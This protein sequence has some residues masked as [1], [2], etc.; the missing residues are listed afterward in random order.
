MRIRFKDEE[1]KIV[2]LEAVEVGISVET[3]PANNMEEPCVVLIPAATSS[4]YVDGQYASF[5][6]RLTSKGSYL[7]SSLTD[8]LIRNGTADLKDIVFNFISAPLVKEEE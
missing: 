5:D 4:T 2:V 6:S 1:D 8:E 7:Y 3:N